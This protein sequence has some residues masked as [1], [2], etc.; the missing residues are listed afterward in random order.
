MRVFVAEKSLSCLQLS[1]TPLCVALQAPLSRGFSRREDWSG[2]P[3]PSPGDL[4]DP[5][6][7][8]GSPTLEADSLLSKPLQKPHYEG[9]TFIFFSFPLL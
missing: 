3:V 6:M 2:L 8:P 9:T 5:G 4:P 7:E 1:V